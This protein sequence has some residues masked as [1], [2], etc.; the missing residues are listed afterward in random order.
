MHRHWNV[1]FVLETYAFREYVYISGTGKEDDGG[2]SR[3]LENV[4]PARFSYLPY[5]VGTLCYKKQWQ[6]PSG[7]LS[8]CN[9]NNTFAGLMS[10]RMS[11]LLMFVFALRLT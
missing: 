9:Y 6:C 11:D 3:Y 7:V 10:A 8:S 5:V 1:C 4:Y 2:G